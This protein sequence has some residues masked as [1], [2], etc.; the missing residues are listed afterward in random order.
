LPASFGQLYKLNDLILDHNRLLFLPDNITALK[1]LRTFE[2]DQ[3]YIGDVPEYGKM[4]TVA[5]TLAQTFCTI[6]AEE[7]K[8]KFLMFRR[9]AGKVQYLLAMVEGRQIGVVNMTDLELTA[10]PDDV[11]E[12][13]GKKIMASPSRHNKLVDTGS[14]SY[15]S[16]DICTCL[17][18]VGG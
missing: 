10:I 14:G 6:Y 12:W 4:T 3:N 5:G 18:G 17:L 2:V 15:V 11:F 7:E 9:L 1:E 16:L 13:P 8:T